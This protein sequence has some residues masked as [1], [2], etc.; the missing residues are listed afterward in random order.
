MKTPH[1]IPLATLMATTLFAL[2]G[3]S[4]PVLD[5]RNAEMPDGLI[6]ATGA[7]EPFTG[8]VTHVPDSF[9]LSDAKGYAKFV[10]EAGGDGDAVARMWR[11][12]QGIGSPTFLCDVSARKG[13]VDGKAICYVP[14]T[15]T[16]LIEAHFS[17]GRLSGGLVY[18]NPES[19]AQKLIEGSFDAGQPA[20]TEKIY[21]PSTGKLVESVAWSDGT[22]DGDYARYTDDG[23]Q[24]TDRWRYRKGQY[25]GVAETFDADTGK[26]IALVDK[27]VEGKING[28]RK[29][30]DK[31][32][33]LLTDEI[34]VDGKKVANKD[35]TDASQADG[36]SLEG[37]LNQ[38]LSGPVSTNTPPAPAAISPAAPATLDACVQRWTA[39]NHEAA[40]KAGVD[41]AA[42]A[43]QVDEWETWCKQGKEVPAG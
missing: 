21:S 1:R 18:Y 5:F 12:A 33:V 10:Q 41:D 11:F 42:T 30:W 23:T 36:E 25:D 40:A 16:K 32:G 14:R 38:A 34:Y 13:Y 37:R 26:R 39:A 2:T 8:T 43:D 17:E 27:W 20:G 4:K 7:N 3:C 15:D 28:E 35:V 31:N 29:T 19:R 22:Y 6:Y 9:L 24:L